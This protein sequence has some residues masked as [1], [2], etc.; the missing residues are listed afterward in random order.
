MEVGICSSVI[1]ARR[2]VVMWGRLETCGRLEIGFSGVSRQ[3]READCQ[4]AAGFQPAPHRNYH[5]L[6]L[7]IALWIFF[8]RCF[9]ASAAV[10]SIFRS[11]QAISA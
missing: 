4:S 11:C 10:T 6:D 8:H 2:G 5:R 3:L 1:D 9:S 7:R